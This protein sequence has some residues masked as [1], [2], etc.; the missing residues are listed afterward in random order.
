MRA[1]Y[2]SIPGQLNQQNK[3]YSV[4]R[5]GKHERAS[6]RENQFLWLSEAGVALPTY[7]VDEPRHPLAM[8]RKSTLFK[9]FMNDV[10]LLSCASG[11]N[12]VRKLLARSPVN[13]G[14]VYENFVA[15]EL[16]A[17]GHALYYFNNKKLGEVDFL[18]DRP[19]GTVIPV[20]VKSGK[21]Y[22]RFRGMKNV[23]GVP[24]YGLKRGVVLCDGN[25]ET[26]GKITYLPIY[27]AALL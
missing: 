4:S 11:T 27:L 15:Q 3:R 19:D 6:R 14:A 21:D 20:E 22:R 26:D 24:N 13:Y 18:V 7:N 17:G 10:G 23:L 16:A 1:V 8:A 9:L 12:A 25:V 5:L 2:D